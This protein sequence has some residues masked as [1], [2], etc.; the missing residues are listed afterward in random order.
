MPIEI[1]LKVP[2]G[3]VRIIGA[4]GLLAIAAAA[5]LVPARWRLTVIDVVMQGDLYLAESVFRGRDHMRWNVDISAHA[6]PH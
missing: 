6:V 5:V 4:L 1:L 2:A 3:N